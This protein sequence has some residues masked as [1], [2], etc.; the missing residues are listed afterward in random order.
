MLVYLHIHHL[1]I[2]FR[3]LSNIFLGFIIF[4]F[5]FLVTGQSFGRSPWLLGWWS[6]PQCACSKSTHFQ[7]LCH[8]CFFRSIFRRLL[9]WYH[10]PSF[11]MYHLSLSQAPHLTKIEFFPTSDSECNSGVSWF[12]FQP[13]QWTECKLVFAWQWQGNHFHQKG[14]S[15][16]KFSWEQHTKNG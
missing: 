10:R 8:P 14:G 2:F 5:L 9:F 4:I 6:D 7:K 1:C 11:G 15:D 12:C 3:W 16:R 13:V